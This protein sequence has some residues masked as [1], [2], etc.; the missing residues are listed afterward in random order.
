MHPRQFIKQSKVLERPRLE[1]LMKSAFEKNFTLVSGAAGQGKTTLV[2][3]AL[4]D[5]GIPTC[6]YSIDRRGADCVKFIQSLLEFLH[7]LTS[8]PLN[9]PDS[10]E[11][12]SIEQMISFLLQY[13]EE[14]A[15]E[16]DFFVVLDNYHLVSSPSDFDTFLKCLVSK[17][18]PNC[19]FILI[20]RKKPSW[21][22][23]SKRVQHEV[24]EINHDHITFTPMETRDFFSEILKV[25]LGPNQLKS[26][27]NL[28]EGWVAAM[29][30]IGEKISVE[31][32]IQDFLSKDSLAIL[33]KIPA[34]N[35]YLEEEF[36]NYLTPE[37][38][39]LLLNTSILEEIP[40]DLGVSIGGPQT[41][42]LLDEIV[43][44]NVLVDC[45]DRIHE[46]YR[47]HNLFRAFLYSR[48]LRSLSADRLDELQQKAGRYYFQHGKWKDSFRHYIEGHA[49]E[50]AVSVLK[51]AGPEILD[52]H[53]TEKLYSLVTRI[54]LGEMEADPWIQLA[55]ACSMRFREPALC[56]NYLNRAFEGF[57]FLNDSE[58]L[59]QVLFLKTEVLMFFPGDLHLMQDTISNNIQSSNPKHY[60][61]LR[62]EAY[63]Q[64]YAAL[65]HCYLTGR[66]KEA[67]KLAEQAR[68]TSFILQDMNLRLWACWALAL[69]SAFI[70]NFNVAQG[71]L[72][73]ALENR[74]SPDNDEII[75]AMIPYLNGLINDFMGD[76]ARAQSY[77]E[78]AAH[79]SKDLKLEALDFYIHHYASYASDYL[80]DQAAS[81]RAL[82]EMAA[83][84]RKYLHSDNHHLIS[85][86]FASKAQHAF[87]W[88]QGYQ[89]V[90]WA[91][92]ALNSRLQAGGEVYLTQCH[93]ILGCALLEIGIL[94]QAESHLLKS[95]EIGIAIGSP[96]FEASSC[97]YLSRLYDRSGKQEVCTQY[98]ERALSLASENSFYHF[99][100]WRDDYISEL[101]GQ[102]IEMVSFRGYIEELCRRRSIHVDTMERKVQLPPGDND[103]QK[104]IRLFLLGPFYMDI[105]GTVYPNTI[106]RKAM[107][108]L[109]LL[110]VKTE[111]VAVSTLMEE[112]WPEWDAKLARNN[113]YFT[114][115]Q[116]RSMLG[117]TEKICFKDGF[118]SINQ[119]LFWID[120]H[121]FNHL[122]ELAKKACRSN[123][124][125]EAVNLLL[126]AA[127]LYR[128]EF[129][130][131][132][133]L[134][135]LLS[136]ERE[137]VAKKYHDCLVT[138]GS[139]FL[140]L[141]LADQA[142]KVLSQACSIPFSEERS[143][144]LLMLAH[145]GFG[146][147]W[148][149]L[150][151]YSTLSQ[152]LEK[153]V[154]S[155]PH[156]LTDELRKL[157]SSEPAVSLPEA[158]NWLSSRDGYDCIL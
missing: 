22:L 16:S 142:V 81:A 41:L 58:G 132:D 67:L 29:L 115:H 45:T 152:Y 153:E 9:Q 40:A 75:V 98:T 89:T 91:R 122:L 145:Y 107:N 150:N 88:K 24:L 62:T 2:A 61:D 101:V 57:T 119:D 15:I 38:Q 26:I 78:M 155:R 14:C 136:R 143:Y 130:E 100:M 129:L 85:F 93:L 103:K 3:H 156:K 19:H 92:Q 94:D 63:K 140:K 1:K 148:Q 74:N 6:W 90:D 82:D 131:G 48:A 133:N 128:G 46:T 147:Q 126:K 154:G 33:G 60:S 21:G 144:R 113:F 139:I 37:Q 80:G 35:L 125:Q 117:G 11:S 158:I 97:V 123:N 43:A 111:P 104:P 138:C 7:E 102:A 59:N 25:D 120:V 76:F 47:C 20:S 108:L 99:F 44:A 116:L 39:T 96:F 13:A 127:D 53:V 52:F 10:L 4:K 86:Y 49:L 70:G 137:V 106:R 149:A 157:L 32:D 71:Y 95:L 42:S 66:M 27:Q 118:C 121:Y 64:V 146:N 84:V 18:R 73:E 141:G 5:L 36:F 8:I 87:Q 50:Q 30:L 72:T 77:L 54:P 17:A 110:A 109:K 83:T 34:L 28:S 135:E 134:G 65:S 23:V 55:Y 51:H 112:M 114:L 12:E 124:K 31:C 79:E 68:R 69:A 56:Y 151:V 105:E